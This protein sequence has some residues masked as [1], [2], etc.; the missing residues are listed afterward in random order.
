[1]PQR[2]INSVTV[3]GAVEGWDQLLKRFGTKKLADVLA[4]AIIYAENGFPVGEV[5]QAYWRDSEKML[6]E[7]E[8]TAKMYMPLGHVPAIGEVFKNPELALTYRQ[9]AAGGRDAF[10][11]GEVAKKIL[12]TFAAHGGT[13]KAPDLAEYTAEWV[14]PISTT[15]RG[16]TVYELPPNGQGIAALEMLNIMERFPLGRDGPQFGARAAHH[17]RGEEDRLCRHDPL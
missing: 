1:M 17:D 3:P 12:A 7:D 5:V 4:P 16:W 15:Y 10:Y 8:P 11:K 13:M 14:D 6:N 9:I 2:G